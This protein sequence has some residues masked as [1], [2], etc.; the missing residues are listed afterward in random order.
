[1]GQYE[2]ALRVKGDKFVAEQVRRAVRGAARSAPGHG[3]AATVFDLLS[4]AAEAVRVA[5]ACGH[6]L[7]PPAGVVR[8]GRP[9]GERG[10]ARKRG[11]ANAFRSFG[12]ASSRPEQSCQPPRT[13]F[14]AR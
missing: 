14:K 12:S 6:A 3:Q 11:H 1:M 13:L 7:T 8:Q 10:D 4:W 2:E 5:R 9:A